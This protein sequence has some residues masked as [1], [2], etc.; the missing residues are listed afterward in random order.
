MLVDK[1]IKHKLGTTLER[2]VALAHELIADVPVEIGE[3][4]SHLRSPEAANVALEWRKA[5]AGTPWGGPWMSAWLRGTVE[6]PS[7]C[8]GREVFIC[9]A[10]GGIE[11]LLFIDGQVTAG[12]ASWAVGQRIDKDAH[13]IIKRIAACG[14]TGRKVDIAIEAYAGH[15]CVGSQPGDRTPEEI[16]D[17]SALRRTFQ[18]VQILLRR[19]DVWQFCLDLRTLLNLVDVL[20]PNSL[21][22][23]RIHVALARVF[24]TIYQMPRDVS[25]QAWRPALAAGREIMKPLLEAKNGDTTPFMGI[26]GHSHLDTAWKWTLDES[27]RKCARTFS[28]ALDLIDRYPEYRFLQSAPCHAEMAREHYPGVFE[29]MRK[30]AAD[31]RW[32]TNGG[33]WVEPDCNIP[34]GESMVRQFLLGQAFTEKWFGCRSDAMW[35]PD[36]FGYSAALPQILQGCGIRFFL[37]TKIAWNDT[38]RFPYDTFHW[39][40]IDGTSVITHFNDIH[41]WPEPRTLVEQWNRVQHKDVQD[42]KY[43]AY[44]HGDGGGGPH[45][46]MVEMARRAGDLE[47]CPRARYMTVSEFMCGV[48]RDLGAALPSYQGELYLECHRGTLTSIHDLKRGNRKAELALRDAEWASA[49]TRAFGQPYPADRF[50]DMWQ[51]LLTNQF[52]DI[53]PGSSMNEV[54]DR[55]IGEFDA[56]TSESKDL[57]RKAI[58][59]LGKAAATHVTLANSLSW[60]RDGEIVLAGLAEGQRPAGE[61]VVA[62][63]YNDVEGQ[64]LT[65]VT[66]VAIPSLGVVSVPMTS[67]WNAAASPFKID[68]ESAETP[69]ASVRFDNRGRMVSFVDKAARRELVR[70]GGGFNVFWCG[71]DLPRSWDNWDIDPD[72]NS[73]MRDEARLISKETVSDGPLQLRVR[74][75]YE[76]AGDAEI[77]QD[78]V[79]HSTT[80]RVDFETLLEWH[81]KHKLLKVAFDTT[82]LSDDARHEIQ[83][84]HLMRP[85]HRNLTTDR[86]RFE[87]SN[88]KWTDLSE[89]RYGIAILND[90]KYGISVLGGEMRLS[91]IKSGT[92]PDWRG[93]A[94]THRVNYALLPHVCGFSAEA[95]VKPA[96]EFNVPAVTLPEC[97]VEPVSLAW[98]DAA[99]VLADTVKW[100]EDGKSLVIRL[101]ECEKTHTNCTLTF[102]IDVKCVTQT[103]MLEE[104]PVDLTLSG[105]E[106]RLEFRPFEVKTLRVDLA[107]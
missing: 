47:G 25:E 74:C 31:G 92:H 82:V 48:E 17:P 6:L 5:E 38:N 103:N 28:N 84:G 76:I 90:C 81:G 55:A 43:S 9:A 34:S 13:H 36:V 22:C 21:R 106:V 50:H 40:G 79:F 23:N 68:R 105:R 14:K 100:S 73:K 7:S 30:A 98:T 65:A 33:M 64:S 89:N 93:D 61:G 60:E 15:P 1:N 104:D 35:L 39:K 44:G 69:F 49:L 86:S 12:L 107:G 51:V 94:G 80:P 59:A 3:T 24:E 41:C 18:S 8:E 20:D 99:N 97:A 96:Y 91:L 71:E 57:C 46:E 37:T 26:A 27:I 16:R 29:R 53:L 10:H 19:D 62:Q 63:G 101:Y 88:H 58:A 67:D 2:Y 52:H 102:G 77:T 75:R 66:G 70:D 32:E 87:V 54:N 56:I 45:D 95:V 4:E 72:Q 83:F 78:I 42:R 11:G 85:A